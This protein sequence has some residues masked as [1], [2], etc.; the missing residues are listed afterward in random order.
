MNKSINIFNNKKLLIFDYDGTIADTETLHDEAFKFTLADYRLKF[1]YS[2]IAG[3]STED[4]LLEIFANNNIKTSIDI[5]I[6]KEKKLISKKFDKLKILGTGEIK[7]KIEI[8][9]HFAS[10]QALSKI[11]KAGGKISI[12]KK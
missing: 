11:E 4:A 1:I 6:L 3:L 12:V 10:K 7:K 5:K 9:A 2:D 8:A